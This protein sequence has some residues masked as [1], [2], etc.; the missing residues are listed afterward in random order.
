[1]V[2]NL[3]DELLSYIAVDLQR[4]S[5]K[6]TDAMLRVHDLLKHYNSDFVHACL[7]HCSI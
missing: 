5:K 7:Q 4:Y 1:M 3:V 2:K 6:F